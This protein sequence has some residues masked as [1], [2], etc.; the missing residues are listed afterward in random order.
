MRGNYLII[1]SHKQMCYNTITL[2]FH[3]YMDLHKLKLHTTHITF[4]TDLK[5]Y[6]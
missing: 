5:Y 1:P 4:E 6:T 2:N 3:T